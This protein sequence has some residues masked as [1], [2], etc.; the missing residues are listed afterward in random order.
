MRFGVR[1]AALEV[2]LPQGRG[3]EL[4]RAEQITDSR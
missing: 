2:L 3:R 4:F 1:P